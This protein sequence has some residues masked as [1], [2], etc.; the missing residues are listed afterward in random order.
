MFFDISDRAKDLQERLQAFMDAH[1]Y[2][3]EAEY[4]PGSF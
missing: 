2:P 4:Y 1:I 3:N